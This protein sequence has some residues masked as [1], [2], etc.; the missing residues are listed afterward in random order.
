MCKITF[1]A[2]EAFL[3]TLEKWEKK[4][5][6]LEKTLFAGKICCSID[7]YLSPDQKSAFQLNFF[8]SEQGI[9]VEGSFA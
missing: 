5:L 9:E 7:Q 2:A 4:V 8:L 1:W 6:S 3:E